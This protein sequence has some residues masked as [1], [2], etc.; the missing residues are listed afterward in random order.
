MPDKNRNAFFKYW[1][2]VILY[3]AAIFI[4]SSIPVPAP[5]KLLFP[6][7]DKVLHAIE[8][9]IL[10][11]LLIRALN[12]SNKDKTVFMLRVLAAA[13]AI[14]Y[15]FTDE[16]HQHFVPGRYME[17]ADFLSDGVG[18]YIGQLF[19]KLRRSYGTD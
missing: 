12:F 1:L 7:A 19:F 6:H 4:S 17:I 8:Y 15:A 5:P 9:A 14:F 2:P 10:G 18:A 16:L 3:A 13:A 11:F